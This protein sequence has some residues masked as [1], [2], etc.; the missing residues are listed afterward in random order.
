M[1][2]LPKTPEQIEMLKRYEEEKLAVLELR[3]KAADEDLA[4]IAAKKKVKR[5]KTIEGIPSILT[6][7]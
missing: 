2:S 3:K 1:R 7:S 5:A 6:S 4:A